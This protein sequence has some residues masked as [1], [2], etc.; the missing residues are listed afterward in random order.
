M[1]LLADMTEPELHAFFLGLALKLKASPLGSTA[2]RHRKYH[3]DRE[4]AIKMLRETAERLERR[5]DV[6]R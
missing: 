3:K 5:Q 4:N 2:S 6:T 1:K